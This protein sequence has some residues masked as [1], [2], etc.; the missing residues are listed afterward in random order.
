MDQTARDDNPALPRGP[1][2][3]SERSESA[4]RRDAADNPMLPR[5]ALPDEIAACLFD[6]DGVLTSTANIHA[7]AWKSTFDEFLRKRACA[8]GERFVPFD[9]VS[10]YVRY[11]DGRPRLEGTQ[12]FLES[13]HIRLPRGVATDP[14][15]VATIHGISR[16]KNDDLLR[17]LRTGHVEAFPS[18]VRFV[19]AVRRSG[20]HAAV[21]SSSA[22]APTVLDR[23][24]VAQLFDVVID[25]ASAVRNHLAGKPA[26]DTFEA[27]AEALR[28]DPEHAAVF[29]DS[30]VGIEAGRR[31]G[32]GFV[33]GIGRGEHAEKLREAGADVVLA[34]L[35]ELSVR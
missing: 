11:V 32:F 27:A 34:D 12:A 16:A 17:R 13:R 2:G 10:D 23:A 29:E 31:G 26:P 3:L 33:V 6:L 7:A 28:V 35:D 8:R 4:A 21:V 15:G 19:T 24:H 30:T 9:A 25:G 22:N 20:R 5:A 18:A 14:P 1:S